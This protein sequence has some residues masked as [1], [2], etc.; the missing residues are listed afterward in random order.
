MSDSSASTDPPW[1]D[2]WRGI[3]FANSYV[4]ARTEALL[5]EHSGMSLVFMDVLGRLHD[6][7][8]QRLRM[9]ELQHRSLFTRTG[10]T[11]LVDRIETA[12]YATREQVPGDRRGVYVKITPEGGRQYESAVEQHRDDLEQVFAPLLTERQHEAVAKALWSFWHED[13]S[14]DEDPE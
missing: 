11:R 6:A 9:Q 12:G 8:D 7:P 2:A 14:A 5:Q 10:M 13:E 3:L 4:L 1:W